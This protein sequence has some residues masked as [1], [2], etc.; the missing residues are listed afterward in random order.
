MTLKE[1]MQ[2]AVDESDPRHTRQVMDYLRFKMGM[3]YEQSAEY[4][5]KHTGIDSGEFEGLCM[6]A[7]T[8]TE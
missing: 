8:T 3:N 7:D 2:K 4:F 1:A 6:V 5:R